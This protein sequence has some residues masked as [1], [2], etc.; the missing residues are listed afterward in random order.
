MKAVRRLFVVADMLASVA[1]DHPDDGSV[2]RTLYEAMIDWGAAPVLAAPDLPPFALGTPAPGTGTT[3]GSNVQ[4]PSFGSSV[5][6]VVPG[7]GAVLGLQGCGGG[8]EP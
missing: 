5:G 1:A 7:G 8:E 4:R 6:A 2:S 3:I